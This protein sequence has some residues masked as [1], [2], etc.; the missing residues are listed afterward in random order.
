[1]TIE[2]RL[3]KRNNDAK[4]KLS[5]QD[6]V[7]AINLVH[8][9]ICANGYD[10]SHTYIWEQG[11]QLWC[12]LLQSVLPIFDHR[13]KIRVLDF[14]CGTGF[15][16]EQVIRFFGPA[17]IEKMVIVEPSSEMLRKA[18]EKLS[19][20]S[21]QHE[22]LEN[23]NG[24]KRGLFDIVCENSV[25]H[26]LPNPYEVVESLA[27][28]VDLPGALILAH[29][30]NNRFQNGFIGWLNR[31]ARLLLKIPRTRGHAPKASSD[32]VK[33]NNEL[34]KRGI[35]EVPVPAEDLGMIVDFYVPRPWHPERQHETLGF[36]YVQLLRILP[37]FSLRAMYTYQ[38]L[39][40]PI[41]QLG[42]LTRFLDDTLR[43]LFPANGQEL[44]LVLEKRE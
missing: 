32:R 44:A 31:T 15:A 5:P 13:K 25:I 19:Q 16:A 33:L 4:T 34:M 37:H 21:V 30:P 28:L 6:F 18:R 41:T 42:N 40:K 14:G 10:L 27:K 1:M 22:S 8:H 23:I 3:G 38:H 24:L 7:Q 17:R 39:G 9:Q 29:E 35:I 12:S 11:R 43:L 20:L 2:S 36:D 26:H